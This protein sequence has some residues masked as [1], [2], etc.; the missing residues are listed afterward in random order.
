[1]AARRGGATCLHWERGRRGPATS[2]FSFPSSGPV[3]LEEAEVCSHPG[4][5]PSSAA[6]PYSI[7]CPSH[8]PTQSEPPFLDSDHLGFP[9]VGLE[10]DLGH[11]SCLEVREYG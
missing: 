10:R 7:D 9:G 8:P 3:G 1:M 11:R 2:L 5:L 4:W 6:A